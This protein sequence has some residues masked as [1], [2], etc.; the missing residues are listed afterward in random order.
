[1]NFKNLFNFTEIWNCENIAYVMDKLQTYDDDEIEDLLHDLGY[2]AE[3][4]ISIYKEIVQRNTSSHPFGLIDEKELAL[5]AF[6]LWFPTEAKISEIVSI[7]LT[8]H[9]NRQKYELA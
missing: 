3:T 8:F 7:A 2:Y 4:I 5:V 1:M 6:Q 9:S